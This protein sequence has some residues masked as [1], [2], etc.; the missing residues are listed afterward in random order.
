MSKRKRQP[1]STPHK[2]PNASALKSKRKLW[3]TLAGVAVIAL[4]I[5]GI[6]RYSQSQRT[7][8]LNQQAPS[9]AN[10]TVTPQQTPSKKSNM[11]IR[12][13]SQ[14]YVKWETQETKLKDGKKQIEG[15]IYWNGKSGADGEPII[16]MPLHLATADHEKKEL[17][18]I[19]N[20][21]TDENGQF[22]LIVPATGDIRLGCDFEKARNIPQKVILE[23]GSKNRSVEEE[24]LLQKVIDI[25]SQVNSETTW[26]NKVK[27]WINEQGTSVYVDYSAPAPAWYDPKT[28]R[29]VFNPQKALPREQLL[30]ELKKGYLHTF[31]LRFHEELHRAQNR[32]SGRTQANAEMA[33]IR[34]IHAYW[35]SH[36]SSVDEL[37]EYI[38][39]NPHGAYKNLHQTNREQFGRLCA[40]MD[41]LYVYF[42]EDFDKL[43]EYVGDAESVAEFMQKTQTLIDSTVANR[44]GF[45]QRADNTIFSFK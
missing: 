41:W 21:V 37:Y 34:E 32:Q 3:H 9:Q 40:M 13:G 8:Q 38:Y 11:N 29:I 42:D 22:A 25:E 18:V 39:K 19:A 27:S 2:Q 36:L 44:D 6:G 26:G 10:K 45:V 30:E 14:G 16:G 33:L 12:R 24:R 7:K 28:D 1:Q 17:V 23:Q 31:I 4:I 5:V 43:A 15:T 35:I 20:S